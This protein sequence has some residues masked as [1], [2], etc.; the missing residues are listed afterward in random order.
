MNLLSKIKNKFNAFYVATFPNEIPNSDINKLP[1]LYSGWNV[2]LQ[3]ID[4]IFF[5][6]FTIW[7][8]QSAFNKSEMKNLSCKTAENFAS[9]KN[10]YLREFCLRILISKNHHASFIAVNARLNDY[11]MVNRTLATNAIFQ[12]TDEIAVEQIIDALPVI[13]ALEKQSRSDAQRIIFKVK[14]RLLSPENHRLVLKGITHSNP[15]VRLICWQIFES[16][17]SWS[18]L[19]KIQHAINTKDLLIGQIVVPQA[20]DLTDSQILNLIQTSNKIISMQLRRAILLIAWKR[21]LHDDI[22]LINLGL[23]DSSFAIRSMARLWAKNQ[24]ELLTSQYREML[25][26]SAS[27]RKRIFALEGINFLKNDSMLDRCLISLN[28]EHPSI[29]RAALVTICD[30]DKLNQNIYLQQRLADSNLGVVKQ[31][32]DISIKSGDYFSIENLKHLTQ[33]WCGE[34]EFFIRLFNYANQIGG[35]QELH[36]I[37]LSQLAETKLHEELAKIIT[38][39]VA[40]WKMLQIY[41]HPTQPELDD[42]S[43]WLNIDM[44]Q[45]LDLLKKDVQFI[46]QMQTQS[47]KK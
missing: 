9:D 4:P 47:R 2:N 27:I 13:F 20:V 3:E 24:P 46:L 30:I 35:W 37:S 45:K 22:S 34:L 8:K 21:K 32:F 25:T 36:I 31:C 17:S 19:E 16:I 26:Q 38:S 41:T 6:A 40:N 10:G 7:L 15:K 18:A 39:Y 42:I 43:A 23:W 11:V 28:D 12:W 29:R 14:K 44:F 5:D 1:N 33:V